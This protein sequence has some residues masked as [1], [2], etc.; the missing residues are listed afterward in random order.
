MIVSPPY[1]ASRGSIVKEGVPRSAEWRLGNVGGGF[2]PSRS[3]WMLA[4]CPPDREVPELLGLGFL[5]CGFLI[6][7]LAVDSTV[8]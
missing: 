4:E 2:D 6:R 3:L 5:L 1:E 7:G 8:S